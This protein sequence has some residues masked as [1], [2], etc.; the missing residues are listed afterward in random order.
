MTTSTEYCAGTDVQ[1]RQCAHE[2]L[3]DPHLQAPDEIAEVAVE[4]AE[5]QRLSLLAHTLTVGERPFPFAFGRHMQR[6]ALGHEQA[7]VV[8]GI[9]C[10]VQQ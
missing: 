10:T 5:L 2:V 1:A 7:F 3:E 4:D 9:C 6:L 8:V